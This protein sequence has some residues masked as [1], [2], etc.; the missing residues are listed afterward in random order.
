M[1]SIGSKRSLR[2]GFAAIL[3]GISLLFVAG[4]SA[5]TA[6]TS[7]TSAGGGSSKPASS[8]NNNAGDVWVDNVGQ[9]PGPGHEMDPHLACANIILWG[10]DLADTSGTFTIDGWPPSGSGAGNQAWPGTKASPGSAHWSYTLGKNGGTED[11]LTND[12]FSVPGPPGQHPPQPWAIDVGKLVAN[13]QANG[14]APINKQ[15]FHFKLQFS[16]DPQKHKTFWVNCPGTTTSTSTTS[17]AGGSGGTTTTTTTT[18]GGS[19]TATGGVAG[20]STSSS[21][22]TGGVAGISTSNTG[23]GHNSGVLGISTS[24]PGTGA[25]ALTGLALLLIA[26]GATLMGMSRRRARK[27]Q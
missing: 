22:P 7:S 25:A 6:A 1:S 24:T 21:G 15:G 14:D 3:G 18:G 26:G 20:T 19:S 16:Q 9:P 2:L 27:S 23:S 13:A 5:G 8:G 11:I 12:G 17:S 4:A 10:S